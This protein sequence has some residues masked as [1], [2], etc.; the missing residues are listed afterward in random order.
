MLVDTSPEIQNI[1]LLSDQYDHD[2]QMSLCKNIEIHRVFKNKQE[3]LEYAREGDTV[4]IPSLLILEGDDLEKT[5]FLEELRNRNTVMQSF[6]EPY[7][8]NTP[9]SKFMATT[10]IAVGSF[11][12]ELLS[13]LKQINIG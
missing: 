8:N 4:C 13:N 12:P 6:L 7:I 9:A 11:I 10:L 2:W 1:L 3:L 5:T